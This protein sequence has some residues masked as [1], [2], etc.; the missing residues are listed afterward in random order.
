MQA[1]SFEQVR[2]GGDVAVM[3]GPRCSGSGTGFAAVTADSRG[4]EGGLQVHCSLLTADTFASR[5]PRNSRYSIKG[6]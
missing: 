5:V 1:M 3:L 6:I 2:E 4:G